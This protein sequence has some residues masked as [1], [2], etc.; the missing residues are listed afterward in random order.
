MELLQLRY[1]LIVADM[2]HMTEAAKKLN[3]SQPVLSRSISKLEEELGVP[4]FNRVGRRIQLNDYGKIFQKNIRQVIKLLDYSIQEVQDFDK[5][6]VYEISIQ[7]AAIAELATQ[8]ICD[9]SAQHHNVTFRLQQNETHKV[10]GQPENFDLLLTSA[11][12]E[13]KIPNSLTLF[14]EKIALGV[15]ENHP[16]SKYDT[17][18]LSQIENESFVERHPDNNFR[19]LTDT[20]C[21]EARIKRNIAFECDS[22]Q[23]LLSLVKRGMGVGFIGEKAV[24]IDGVKLL[25]ITDVNC[26]RFVELQWR[27]NYYRNKGVR[28]FISFAQRYFEKYR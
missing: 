21:K 27:E 20:F 6:G 24:K 25:H 7:V 11:R 13:D 4:L 19:K 1:F 10:D 28:E 2:G 9:F 18:E 16:L 14:S 5:I 12:T 8:L 15:S 23:M 26:E 22:P 17:I 3:I